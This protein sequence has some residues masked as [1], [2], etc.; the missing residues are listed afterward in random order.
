VELVK[1]RG[2]RGKVWTWRGTKPTSSRH[3]S[4][5]DCILLGLAIFGLVWLGRVLFTDYGLADLVLGNF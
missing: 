3:L 4:K 1:I 5:W 2:T